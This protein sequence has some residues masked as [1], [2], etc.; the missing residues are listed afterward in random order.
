MLSDLITTS[1]SG[2]LPAVANPNEW[3]HP[4]LPVEV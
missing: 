1:L 2:I 3:A 4:Q